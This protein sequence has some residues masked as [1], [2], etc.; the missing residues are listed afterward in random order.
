LRYRLL[1]GSAFRLTDLWDFDDDRYFY[2]LVCLCFLCCGPLPSVWPISM[3]LFR[4]VFPTFPP[5][6]QRPRGALFPCDHWLRSCRRPPT[7]WDLGGSFKRLLSLVIPRFCFYPLFADL[8]FFFYFFF[9]PPPELGHGPLPT[10]GL[11]PGL[12]WNDPP[13]KCSTFYPRLFPPLFN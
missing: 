7:L 4:L 13:L 11:F 2:F 8:W 5:P 12:R 10:P 9:H 6:G 3:V 1:P